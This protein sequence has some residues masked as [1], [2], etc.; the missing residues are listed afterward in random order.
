MPVMIPKAEACISG[1]VVRGMPPQEA[2]YPLFV[3]EDADRSA[4]VIPLPTGTKDRT[5]N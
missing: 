2:G 1:D 4:V 3:S 5:A